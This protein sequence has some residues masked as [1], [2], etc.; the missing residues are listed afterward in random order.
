MTLQMKRAIVFMTASMF[1]AFSMFDLTTGDFQ[2]ISLMDLA[3]LLP[4]I[5]AAALLIRVWIVDAR[6]KKERDAYSHR[7]RISGGYVS[8]S[9]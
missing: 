1:I 8:P 2:W 6:R 7:M 5:V 9:K 4:S 3:V